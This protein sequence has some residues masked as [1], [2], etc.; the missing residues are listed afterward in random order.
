M[1]DTDLAEGTKCNSCGYRIDAAT[2][3]NGRIPDPGDVSICIACGEPEVFVM[4]PDGL[5]TASVSWEERERILQ[6]E[7]AGKAS[8]AIKLAR[9]ITKD[10]PK[11]EA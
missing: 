9:S 5:T 6:D 11:G 10:W 4:C 2:G 7:V 8:A 1:V 3:I